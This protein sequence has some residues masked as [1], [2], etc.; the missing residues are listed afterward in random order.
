MLLNSMS[1]TLQAISHPLFFCLRRCPQKGNRPI[2]RTESCMMTPTKFPSVRRRHLFDPRHTLAL[3]AVCLVSATLTAQVPT[4]VP[5][6][7]TARRI[8]ELVGRMTLEEKVSQMQN[9]AA[10]IPRLNVPAYNWW[11][12]GLHGVARSGYATVF[13]RP[14]A[15]QPPGTCR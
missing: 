13:P 2:L 4:H 1:L 10:A 7:E 11:N 3:C 15:W 8:S 6:Q 12:E 5:S 14:L 9:D